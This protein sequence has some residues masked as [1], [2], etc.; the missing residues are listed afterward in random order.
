M[1]FLSTFTQCLVT[2]I[3]TFFFSE[4]ILCVILC[5]CHKVD[6]ICA[7]LPTYAVGSVDSLIGFAETSLKIQIY[8]A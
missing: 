7:F 6:E 2:E 3:S 1:Q 8:A 4:T 5:V